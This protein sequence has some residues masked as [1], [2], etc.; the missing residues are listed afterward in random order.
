MLRGM[1]MT[2]ASMNTKYGK[3]KANKFV[4]KLNQFS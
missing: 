1:Y 4:N 2:V 3:T